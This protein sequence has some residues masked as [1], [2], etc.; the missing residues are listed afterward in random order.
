MSNTLQSNEQYPSDMDSLDDCIF[1]TTVSSE[2]T[3]S[4]CLKL[5]ATKVGLKHNITPNRTQNSDV[6]LG[7]IHVAIGSY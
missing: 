5:G 4:I 2:I 1:E 6:S 7:Q 3:V